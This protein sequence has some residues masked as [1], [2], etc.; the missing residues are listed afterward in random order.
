MKSLMLFNVPWFVIN[1]DS[2]TNRWDSCLEEEKNN[3]LTLTRIEA[4]KPKERAGLVDNYVT[5]GVH[6]V[7]ESH[8]KAYI[9]LLNSEHNY[10]VVLE[11]DF[12]IKNLNSLT[13]LV[14]NLNFNDWDMIQLGYITPGIDDRI[15]QL[16]A[17]AES[18]I[19]KI[20]YRFC[21]LTPH[22]SKNFAN[23]LRVIEAGIEP[24]GFVAND[25]QPGGHCYVI[26]KRLA[27]AV[28]LLNKPMFLATDDFY[29]ALSRMR[30]FKII[31][32]R[33]SLVS[34]LPF[35][36]WSGSRFIAKDL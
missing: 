13:K 18:T 6:A 26:S 22:L 15:R 33:K 12:H 5:E 7:W 25:F 17:N 28:L 30:S 34:Q 36:K 9:E 24:K 31:R 20:I 8:L 35:A 29:M 4:C 16:V 23:R 3:G 19:F 10:C 14:Q 27:A 32:V 11:D 21:R 1:V 2:D